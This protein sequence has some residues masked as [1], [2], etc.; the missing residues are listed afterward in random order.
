LADEGSEYCRG[1]GSG[2]VWIPYRQSVV[3]R[4]RSLEVEGWLILSR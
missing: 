1:A 2:E 3:I 4:A